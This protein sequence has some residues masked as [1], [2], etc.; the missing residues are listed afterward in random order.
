MKRM[1]L[2]FEALIAAMMMT[3]MTFAKTQDWGGQQGYW[4]QRKFPFAF[5]TPL[6]RDN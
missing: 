4:G 1:F 6:S 3:V 2:K 5:L